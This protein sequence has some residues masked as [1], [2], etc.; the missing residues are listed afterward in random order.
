TAWLVEDRNLPV[1][2]LAWAWGGGAA[3]D[4]EG[5]EGRA[6]MAAAL[7]SEGAGD[8]RANAFSDSLR[9]AGI[10]LGF[11]AGRDGFEGSFRSL[12]DALPEAL[13]LARLA[14][15]APR[16][17][18]DAI[19]RVKARA[20]RAAQQ[21]QETP[22]GLARRA[23]WEAAFP[24]HPAGRLSTPESLAAVTEAELRAGLAQQLRQ[25]GGLGGLL[26]TASGDIDAAGLRAAMAQLFEGLPPGAPPA[27][28]PLPAM[29]RFGTVRREKA[30]GQSTLLFGQDALA[31]EDADWE[32]FQV[33]L[34]ILAGGGFTSRLTRIVREERG[35]TYG[36]GAGM[37]LLFG[38]AIV[39]GQVQTDN[40]TVGEVWQLVRGAWAQMASEG[41]TEAEVADAVAFL[42]GSLPLQFTDSRRTASLLL[43]LRQ[44][45]RS[46]EWL[47]GR[48]A[49]LAALTR[50]EV[51]SAARRLQPEALG[52]AVA[53]EP[54]GL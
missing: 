44:A 40:A 43:G 16:L 27:V 39:T 20:V 6:G 13:R 26:V 41:P 53:G 30:A 31:P 14:M 23:F 11:G 9:D 34:R 52:L 19:D 10:G 48:G 3:L 38:R 47:A 1:V 22:P 5:R 42:G 7:L 35:L 12:S 2:S 29:A 54:Q 33:A 50:G 15:T 46:P 21:A 8:L 51:A 4:P 49:R 17:D 32:A 18:A 28:P 36:I 24:G 25:G 37:D 45:G